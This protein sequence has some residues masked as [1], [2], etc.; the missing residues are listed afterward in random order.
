MKNLKLCT[1]YVNAY[2]EL[3]PHVLTNEEEGAIQDLLSWYFPNGPIRF[4]TIYHGGSGIS[5]TV[6][7]NS[8]HLKLNHVIQHIT[9]LPSLNTGLNTSVVAGGKGFDISSSFLSSLGESVER[10][11]GALALFGE[12]LDFV[13]G[14]YKCVIQSGRNALSPKKLHLFSN[15]QYSNPEFIFQRFTEDTEIG[16]IKGRHL[17]SDEEI[18]LPAQI[19]LFFYAPSPEETIIGYSASPGM[20]C[21]INEEMA[22]IGGTTEVVERDALM[23]SWY[24]NIPPRR[25][26]IDR[27]MRTRRANSFLKHLHSL[28]D[29]VS[30]WLHDA[31]IP[32]LPVISAVQLLPSYKKFRYYVGAAS[33]MDG[34]DAFLQALV[35]YGQSEIQ[36]KLANIAPQR[37]WMQGVKLL[38]DVPPDK[39]IHEI[40]SFLETLGYYGHPEN[41]E[42]INSF[43]AGSEKVQLSELPE[44]FGRSSDCQLGLLK[45]ILKE[46]NIDPIIIDFTPKQM[47]Q[48]KIIRVFIPELVLPHVSSNPYL[49]HPRLFNVPYLLG[50]KDQPIAYEDLN[51]G[52]VPFP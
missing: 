4:S 14:S 11:S 7:T 10:I 34:E 52:P 21:H 20:A 47:K 31:A 27:P 26:V 37:R 22:I 50:L 5:E 23:L 38:F 39:P 29:K 16:W 30:F 6:I 1:T 19:A 9:G 32:E 43:F 3:F 15:E 25:L 40:N 12:N 28:P 13:F 48:I 45:D 8:T 24:S 35:E 17:L 41:S 42:K 51:P 49:G 33:A 2:S 46:H 18:W 36:L 44:V